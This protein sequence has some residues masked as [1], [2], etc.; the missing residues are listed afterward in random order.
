MGMT[1]AE[2][3]L[4]RKS[5][6]QEVRPGDYLTA[7]IDL[8]MAHESFAGAYLNLASAGIQKVWDPDRVVVVLDHY[9]PAPTERSAGIHQIVRSAVEQLGIKHFYDEGRGICHQILPEEG[10]VCPGD[11]IVG[12]DSHTTTYGA[13]GAAGTGIGMSEMA[14][15]LATGKLW[16]RVPS[17]I[18][19]QLN[20]MLPRRVMSKDIILHIA[21]KYRAEVAQYRSVEFSGPTAGSLSVDGRMTMSN[22][23]LELGAKFGFFEPDEKTIA[24]LETRVKGPIDPIR[25]D[26]DVSYEEVYEV[27]V[28][29]LEPQIA[30]PWTVDNV[31]PVSEVG[32]VAVNQAV[33]GSCT[34]GRAE[35]LEV[36]AEILRNKKIHP[37]TRLLVFPASRA[38][39]QEALRKGWLEAL[40]EAG[41]SICPPGCGVC[42][43]AHMGLLAAGE[44]CVAS[45]NRNFRGRMGSNDARVYLGSPATVAA[46]AIEGKIADPR[47]Y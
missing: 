31:K 37:R 25:A 41:A 32:E 46:S 18:R 3:I 36:S 1:L 19:F 40:S 43:G 7:D 11:L 5:G 42:F 26:A 29:G 17:S 27:D 14:Y 39:Y 33:I 35:D 9:V 47:G 30:L 12:A 34:N 15:V 44:S 20:G 10:H 24:Y 2:K 22:M 23:A 13:F 8:A 16:F 6:K 28:S 45:I 21:G 4:A 38:I